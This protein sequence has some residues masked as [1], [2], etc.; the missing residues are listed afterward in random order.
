MAQETGKKILWDVFWWAGGLKSCYT[1]QVIKMRIE[2]GWSVELQGFLW[3]LP[4][5]T[6]SKVQWK[7]WTF[8]KIS[9]ISGNYSE[10][11]SQNV[12]DIVK[13]KLSFLHNWTAKVSSSAGAQDYQ[14]R[15]KGG[16]PLQSTL[17]R[18]P[19][20]RLCALCC[21]LFLLPYSLLKAVQQ[22]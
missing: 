4:A 12:K 6:F 18:G 5:Q 15:H 13:Q 8:R 10:E 11:Q 14:E 21:I 20:A 7:K 9:H 1:S 3:K 16:E 22:Y 19:C 17:F 2:V